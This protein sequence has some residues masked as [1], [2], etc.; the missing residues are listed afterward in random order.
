MNRD[1]K[2]AAIQRQLDA[3]EDGEVK[4]VNTWK[5]TNEV[6]LR[7]SLGDTNPTYLKLI[8]VHFTPQVAWAGMEQ[9][10]YHRARRTGIAS[11]VALMKAAIGEIE[12]LEPLGGEMTAPG[13]TRVFIVHGRD[14]VRKLEIA[15]LVRDLTG[16][17]AAILSEYPNGGRTL[18]EKF[19]H[20]AAE[21][22]YAI[23]IASADDEGR[24]RGTDELQP[25]ARQ[26]VVFELGYFIGKLGRS[27]V[28]LLFEEGVETPSDAQ[29]IVYILL[30]QNDGW[31]LPLAKEL[32]NAGVVVDF[33]ALAN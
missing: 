19:E 9:S 28:A 7:N 25:R 11:S 10:V 21:A 17:K 27:R 3:V 8:K 22:A 13:G 6:V 20:A 31:K 18:I 26:N 14:E 33:N 23:V 12:L 5:H 24:L 30:D 4:D 15:T 1:Q 2:I 29:G 16:T 32:N